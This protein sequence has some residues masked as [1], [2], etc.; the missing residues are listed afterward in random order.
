MVLSLLLFW[1]EGDPCG[2]THQAY[3]L[4]KQLESRPRLPFSKF[5]WGTTRNLFSRLDSKKI[6]AEAAFFSLEY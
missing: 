1:G 4:D 2:R 6:Q 3:R 5:S